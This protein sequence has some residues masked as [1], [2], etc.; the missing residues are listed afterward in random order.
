MKIFKS[1][2]HFC[3]STLFVLSLFC[4]TPDKEEKVQNWNN[5][6]K[7]LEIILASD[8]PDSVKANKIKILF[9]S[10]QVTLAEYRKFYESSIAKDPL[11]HLDYLKG[12]EKSI[13]EDMNI[14]ARRQKKKGE[15]FDYRKNPKEKLKK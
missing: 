7:D 8:N 6:I 11:R 3:L 15:M 10:N 9:D 1:S 12:I 2:I 13:S 5:I 14:E 4:T